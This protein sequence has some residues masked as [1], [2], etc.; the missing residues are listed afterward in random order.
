MK[1]ENVIDLI[2]PKSLVRR[3]RS[4]LM[5]Q[6]ANLD[7]RDKK[8][9]EFESRRQARVEPHK[10]LFFF[11]SNDPY[12]ALAAQFLHR[13]KTAYNIQLEI[14]LVGEEGYDALPEPEMY[15]KY[16]FNDVQELLHITVLISQVHSFHLLIKKCFSKSFMHFKPT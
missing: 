11:Q 4:F 12:S 15:R 3:I 5:N 13:I 7:I 9:Q 2:L 8:R 10:V 6:F 16:V 1:L 14:C